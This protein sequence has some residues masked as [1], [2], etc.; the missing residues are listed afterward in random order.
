MLELDSNILC[1]GVF[2]SLFGAEQ[3]TRKDYTLF[4]LF[5]DA[6]TLLAEMFEPVLLYL[7]IHYLADTYEVTLDLETFEH[8]S[9]T[10]TIQASDTLSLEI[11]SAAKEILSYVDGKKDCFITLPDPLADRLCDV[12]QWA[13]EL[14]EFF[15]CLDYLWVTDTQIGVGFQKRFSEKM[16][17]R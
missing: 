17:R 13:W 12:C 1:E 10:L 15:G 11:N 9:T 3:F 8:I 7:I 14:E 16:D 2:H 4:I 6:I 5:A